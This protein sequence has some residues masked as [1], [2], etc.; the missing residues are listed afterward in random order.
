MHSVELTTTQNSQ[1]AILICKDEPSM[2]LREELVETMQF[3]LH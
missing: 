2:N 3:M 1:E